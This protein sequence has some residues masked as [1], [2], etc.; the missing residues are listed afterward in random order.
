MK[1]LPEYYGRLWPI[2]VIGLAA[3]LGSCR[4][5]GFIVPPTQLLGGSLNTKVAEQSPR[6]SYDGR[7]LAFAS[8][9]QG[10]RGV[11]V[12]DFQQRRL[13]SLPGLNQPGS[14]QDQPD[15][16]ADG[17]Y[18]VYLSEQEGKPDIFLYDRQTL[19]S[20]NLTRDWVGEV[21]QPAI[22]GNGR[23]VAFEANRGGQWDIVIY[24][25]GGEIL[26]SLP[27]DSPTQRSSDGGLKK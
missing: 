19:Q 23:F 2:L 7:Y 4:E 10:K 24:D 5:S 13:L 9:R 14:L 25:R 3:G 18:L 20:E 12:Y 22:S 21:R 11:W 26:P 17:R 16:S 15:I 1:C 27:Q 8:D 6:F